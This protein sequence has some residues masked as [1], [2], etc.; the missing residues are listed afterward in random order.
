ML[1]DGDVMLMLKDA[2][3]NT[4]YGVKSAYFLPILRLCGRIYLLYCLYICDKADG[5]LERRPSAQ[6]AF[7]RGNRS[8]YVKVMSSFYQAVVRQMIRLALSVHFTGKIFI[9]C[10]YA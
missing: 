9:S 3:S 8:L 4:R 6:Q 2:T 10:Q 5:D 7:L 1:G